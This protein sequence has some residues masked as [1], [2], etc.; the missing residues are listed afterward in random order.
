MELAARA[1]LQKQAIQRRVVDFRNDL[2]RFAFDQDPAKTWNDQSFH[3]VGFSKLG[4]RKMK[5]RIKISR[6]STLSGLNA[7]VIGRSNPFG[8]ARRPLASLASG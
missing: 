5:M 1:A 8:K 4:Q 3:M 6:N 2:I 7:V